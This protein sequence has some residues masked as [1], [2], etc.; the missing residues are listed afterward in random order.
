[1]ARKKAV[2]SVEPAAPDRDV[3]TAP[4]RRK[5]ALLQASGKT[6]ARRTP[7]ADVAPM[8]I[9]KGRQGLKPVAIYMNPAAKETLIRISESHGK[10]I[11]MLGLEALNLLFEQYDEKPV[12]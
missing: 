9:G 11:Q 1:M 3:V 8:A 2:G 6:R 12:A 4:M 7:K 5:E 10:T